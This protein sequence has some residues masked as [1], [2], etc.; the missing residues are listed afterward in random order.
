[1]RSVPP[2]RLALVSCAPTVAL[3]AARFPIDEPLDADGLHRA[4]GAAEAVAAGALPATGR[5]LC[6]GSARACQ[7]AAALGLGARKGDV[8]IPRAP[9]LPVVPEVDPALRDL[10][11]GAWRG[12]SLDEIPPDELRRWHSDPAVAPPGGESLLSLLSRVENWLVRRSTEPSHIIAVTHPAVIRGVLVAALR[13][14][15]EMFW[16]IDVAPL[17]ATLLHHRIGAGGH[18]G[19]TGTQPKTESAATRT[20]TGTGTGTDWTLTHVCRPL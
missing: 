4:A 18:D 6:D 5:V 11:V 12:R 1:M 14:P 15:V 2:V 16:R 7:T 20:A 3:R 19:T 17:T 10:D 13:C 9:G 8:T